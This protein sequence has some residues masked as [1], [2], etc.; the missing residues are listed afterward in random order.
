VNSS[1]LNNG[2]RIL[3]MLTDDAARVDN[4]VKQALMLARGDEYARVHPVQPGPPVSRGACGL[5]VVFQL[6]RNAKLH[7]VR[8]EFVR[9]GE[10]QVFTLIADIRRR[11]YVVSD[12]GR[13]QQRAAERL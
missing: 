11:I 6:G 13:D 1:R 9:A 4:L 10:D 7:Q 8:H 5:N 12:P 2:R 3:H